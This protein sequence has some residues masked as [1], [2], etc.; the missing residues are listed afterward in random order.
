MLIKICGMRERAN[1]EE[2]TK[3]KPDFMGFIFYPKSKRYVGESFDPA[4]IPAKETG[5]RPVAV[6]VN[7]PLH[8]MIRIIQKYHFS[9][10][11]LHGS[12]SP[13]DCQ[14]VLDTGVTVLKAFGIHAGFNWKELD[15]YEE[16]CDYFLF[17][18]STQEHGG[19]GKKFDWELLMHQP[20]KKPF[21]LSGGIGPEDV[22]N[23]RA[24]HHPGF[25]GIDINSRFELEPGIKDKDL[26]NSFL[27][28]SRSGKPD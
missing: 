7:E 4:L 1:I 9:A 13:G 6:F 20:C 2:I 18:T 26:I 12:E 14:K 5:I 22:V 8:H 23:L 28:A 16:V 24:F 10:V 3:L 25:A 21:F 17:D 19:S 11:Q 27:I 15:R